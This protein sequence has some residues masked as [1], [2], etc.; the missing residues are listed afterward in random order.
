MVVN[1]ILG[2]FPS[3][4]IFRENEAPSK[5]TVEE[6]GRDFD[7]VMIFCTN[8]ND[9][10]TFRK[11]VEADY[12]RSIS[13]EQFLVPKFEVPLSTFSN[14][15]EVGILRIN[16]TDKLAEW[17]D[18]SALRHWEVMRTVVPSEIWDQW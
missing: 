9:K 13:R 10:I 17:H 8:T 1:T 16:E 15:D 5:D 14:R 11:P 7:N 3:C 18:Q 4:R 2:I 12:L 6:A